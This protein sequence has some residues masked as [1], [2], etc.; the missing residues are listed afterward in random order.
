MWPSSGLQ[1]QM[2]FY[3]SFLAIVF[4]T[5]AVEMTGFLKG[6]QVF[7]RIA[8]LGGDKQAL[9]TVDIIFLKTGLMLVVLL[10]SIGL[11]MTL[12][13]KKIMIPLSRILDTV[14]KISEGDLSATV[15]EYTRD[16][17]GE[18]ACRINDLS[19]NY[20]ELLLLSKDITGQMKTLLDSGNPDRQE[21]EMLREQ[22]DEIIDEFG[23]HFYGSSK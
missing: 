17:L 18:L 2:F 4:I 3:I 23:M 13:T 19:A 14:R 12:F 21:I 16:E 7:G 10:L 1:K 8:E 6:N 5:M 9:E 20:Q 11:V 22:L 15:P